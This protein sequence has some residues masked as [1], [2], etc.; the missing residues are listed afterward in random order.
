MTWKMDCAIYWISLK[1]KGWFDEAFYTEYDFV[2]RE[3]YHQTNPKSKTQSNSLQA[4]V[5]LHREVFK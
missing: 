4:E 2:C 1:D 3:S 5:F